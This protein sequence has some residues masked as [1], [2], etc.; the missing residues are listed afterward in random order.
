MTKPR[1]FPERKRQR[2]IGAM[3]RFQNPSKKHGRDMSNEAARLAENIP[4]E[5][6]REI[7]TKKVR[8]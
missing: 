7:K 2:R 5:S 6:Q 4:A 8:Q 1:N 3:H